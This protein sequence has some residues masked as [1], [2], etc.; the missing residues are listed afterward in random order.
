M[1]Q[2]VW[3]QNITSNVSVYGMTRRKPKNKKKEQMEECAMDLRHIINYVRVTESERL[4]LRNLK[5][6]CERAEFFF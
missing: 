1:T 3:S 6:M 5:L 4:R 2:G